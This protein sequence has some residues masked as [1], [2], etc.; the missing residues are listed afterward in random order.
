MSITIAIPESIE[1]QLQQE[2]GDL[3]RKALEAL[4]IEGYRSEALSAGQVAELLGL[5]VIETEAFLKEHGV[6]LLLT[7]EDFERD[8]AA[9][10]KSHAQ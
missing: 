3:D 7:I 6:D 10:K 5:S 4:A 8:Q 9:L 1:R 2:W